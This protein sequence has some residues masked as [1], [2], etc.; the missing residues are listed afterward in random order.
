MESIA[1]G[2]AILGSGGGGDT[3]IGLLIARQAVEEAGPV[4]L[5]GLDELPSEGLV[6]P[7]GGMGAPTVSFEKLESGDEGERLRDAVEQTFGRGVVAVMASEI[8]GSNALTPI[9]WAAHMSLPV[10]DADGMGRAFPELHQV[11]MHLAGIAPTPAFLTDERGNL[12]V[13]RA[14]S[15]PWL[16]RIHR[17]VTMELGGAASTA[18][19][20]MSVA[21][22]REAS[23]LGT[24][25]LAM[26][27]G[28][29]L[30]LDA[31]VEMV[32]AHRRSDFPSLP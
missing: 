18:E 22:A 24:I 12:L 4:E 21:Q 19:Y 13:T 14:V 23:I 20:V 27:I 31:L 7:C 3:G 11:A 8:G 32:H 15:G 16:E 6:L 10:V 1:R 2:A 26:R 30:S 28:A 25:S 29:A 17:Q 5:V 9:A